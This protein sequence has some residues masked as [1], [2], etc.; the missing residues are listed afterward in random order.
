MKAT[1]ATF[2]NKESFVV[3]EKN[4]VTIRVVANLNEDAVA[5]TY[6]MSLTLNS[7]KATN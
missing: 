7:A 4:P 1:P 3:D 5:A 2:T 6:Q